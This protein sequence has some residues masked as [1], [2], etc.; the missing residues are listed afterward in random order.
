M[1]Q[2]VQFHC[3][4]KSTGT[5]FSIWNANKILKITFPHVMNAYDVGREGI[6]VGALY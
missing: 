5:K 6:M 2:R 1:I 3:G 4:K